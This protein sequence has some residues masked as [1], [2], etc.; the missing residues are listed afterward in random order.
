MVT[1]WAVFQLPALKVSV[2]VPLRV[3]PLREF[4]VASSPVMETVTSAVGAASRTTVNVVVLPASVVRRLP[5][6]SVVPV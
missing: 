1:V 6:P 5:E 3:E 4:S 2:L